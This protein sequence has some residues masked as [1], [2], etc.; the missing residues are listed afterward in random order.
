MPYYP[1][2]KAPFAKGWTTIANFPPNNWELKS[3]NKFVN[4]SWAIGG[5]WNTKNLGLLMAGKFVSFTDADLKKT[6]PEDAFP[7]LSLTS[8]NLPNSSSSL[9]YL[10]DKTSILPISRATIGLKTKSFRVSYQGEINQFPDPGSLLSF[11][12]LI[13]MGD[14]IKNYLLFLN[15]ESSAVLRVAEIEIF[16]SKTRELKYKT[17]VENNRLTVIPL[18]E[19]LFEPNSL[20]IVIC[21]EMSGIPLFYSIALDGTFLSLE[22]T[23]PPASFVVHGRR[24]DV[25]KILKQKWLA[26]LI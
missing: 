2:L 20:P 13:Q 8:Q 3:S 17:K 25:Q 26:R 10:T 1:I 4:V 15:L 22:H 12:P 7:F 16:D 21:R 5:V 23:H 6:V 24:W 9:P 14:E 18:D 11:S 19:L